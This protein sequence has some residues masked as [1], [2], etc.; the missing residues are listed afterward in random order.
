MRYL[1]FFISYIFVI[2]YLILIL[3]KIFILYM[4]YSYDTCSHI[5]NVF[6]YC[7]TVSS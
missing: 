5:N 6:I 3:H 1:L 7:N 2:I 4:I